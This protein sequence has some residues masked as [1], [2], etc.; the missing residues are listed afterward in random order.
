MIVHEN[1]A[2]AAAVEGAVEVRR[3]GGL[4]AVDGQQV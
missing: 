3:R 1:Q 4:N 2:T